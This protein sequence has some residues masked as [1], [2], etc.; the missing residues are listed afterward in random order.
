MIHASEIIKT[1]CPSPFD[2]IASQ[3]QRQLNRVLG[4]PEDIF[5]FLIGL[6]GSGKTT[7]KTRFLE[8]FPFVSYDSMVIPL[9]KDRTDS[10]EYVR[11]L[12]L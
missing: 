8:G 9:L 11:D 10:E 5:F 7:F 6:P 2:L 3:V 1:T 4:F 12:N